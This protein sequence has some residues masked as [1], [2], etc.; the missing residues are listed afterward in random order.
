MFKPQSTAV[1]I[2]LATALALGPLSTDMY[3]PSL[4]GLTEV[5]NTR[6]DRVQITLSVFLYGFA[7]AQLFYGPLADRFG[8][9]PILLTGLALFTVASF[10]CA[11][12]STIEELILFRFLQALGACSGPVL[13]RTMVRDIHGPVNAAKV[14]SIMGSIMALAPALA[15]VIGGYLAAVFNWNATFIFLTGYGLISFILIAFKVPESLALDNRTSLQPRVIATNF[16]TLFKH[17]I[18][19][20]YTLC[21]SFIFAGLFAFLSGA[22]F[23]LI[24][25]FNVPPE[26]S[27]IFYALASGGFLTGSLIAHRT[28]S[29]SGINGVIKRGTLISVI[30]GLCMLIPAL[31]D[32]HHL[33]LTAITQIVYMC[34][35]GM[36]MPQAM[37]GALAPFAKKAG[38]ASSLLGFIQSLLAASVGML[39]GYY[40]SDTPTAMAFTIALMS[41]L[42]M[43]SFRLLIR[44]D[45]IDLQPSKSAT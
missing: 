10:G 4:P 26:H 12:A 31:L 24:D 7:V 29:Q 41:A 38:T 6:V 23:V 14:L 8:R 20:G 1:I 33:W 34:G 40:H 35:V 43:L 19:L 30:A 17:R 36:V 39:V 16:R 9:K 25:Y 37:A 27:G 32:I 45:K 18:Y 15:P 2:T 11:Q 21:C 28:G 5:F 22:P 13:G 42:A 44:P 3:L